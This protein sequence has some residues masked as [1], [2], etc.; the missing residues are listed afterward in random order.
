VAITT[1]NAGLPSELGRGFQHRRTGRRVGQKIGKFRVNL[2]WCDVFERPSSQVIL[3]R[4][5]RIPN[6]N[7]APSHPMLLGL[8]KALEKELKLLDGGGTSVYIDLDPDQ[9]GIVDVL[10]PDQRETASN[11]NSRKR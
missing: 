5:S 7:C 11:P 3:R 6:R 4:Q 10:S 9:V 8:L 1:A 2:V